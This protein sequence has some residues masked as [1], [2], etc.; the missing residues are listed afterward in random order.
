[1]SIETNDDRTA[2][3]GAGVATDRRWFL[4]SVAATVAAA[5]IPAGAVSWTTPA[6]AQSALRYQGEKTMKTRKLG[7]LEVSEI[8]FGDMG[9]TNGPYG[10]GIDR[11]EGLRV[12]REAYEQG[13]RF[14]DTAEVY[15]P[16]LNEEL[17]GEALAPV[18][19][20]VKIATKFG[21]AINGTN[22]LNSRPEHIRRVVEELLKRL[23]TERIDLYY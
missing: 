6:A 14:F 15:G 2:V 11:A 8:G 10:Q 16:Y 13:V 1:M 17:V 12:I 20:Q 4:I 3:A 21:F 9:L 18:R 22:G 5:A 7:T 23:R 19:D